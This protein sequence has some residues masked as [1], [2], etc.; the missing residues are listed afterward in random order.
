LE[1]PRDLL[2][3]PFGQMLDQLLVADSHVSQVGPAI[4]KLRPQ[5]ARWSVVRN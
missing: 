2:L 1:I 3:S 5:S 4:E